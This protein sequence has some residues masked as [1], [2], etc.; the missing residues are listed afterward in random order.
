MLSDAI[1]VT[2]WP[3]SGEIDI[4]EQWEDNPK[5][6]SGAAHYSTTPL[7]NP[8]HIYDFGENISGIDYS[9]NYHTYSIAWKADEISYYVDGILF[10]HETNGGIGNC[11]PGRAANSASPNCAAQ[12]TQWPFNNFFF[13]IFN[14]AISDQSAGS[15]HYLNDW[16]T[17]SMSIDYVRVYTLDGQGAV[18][19]H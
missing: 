11:G 2:H 4:A 19:T 6:T 13:L 15:N 9:Q 3:F 5:R 7:P 10:L 1:T 17:S 8:Q 12:T 16:S 14:D 18:L